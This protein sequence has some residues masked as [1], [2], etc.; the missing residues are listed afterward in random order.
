MSIILEKNGLFV[1]KIYSQADKAVQ[2]T[3]NKKEAMSFKDKVL[4]QDFINNMKLK[5]F[6][7]KSR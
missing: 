7:I 1:Y 4:A 2:L 5:D 6:I 3:E